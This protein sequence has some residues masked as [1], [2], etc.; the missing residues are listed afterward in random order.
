MV[1]YSKYL[2]R[3]LFNLKIGY[4]LDLAFNTMSIV[5]E[6]SRITMTDTK[7]IPVGAICISFFTVAVEKD[8]Q[9]FC[10]EK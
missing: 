3:H 1:L 9:L 6:I 8:P 4:A 10:Y 2:G 7:I 5:H